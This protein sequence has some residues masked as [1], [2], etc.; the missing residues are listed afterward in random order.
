[1]T[2]VQTHLSFKNSTPPAI[3][4][5]AIV[6]VPHWQLK[7]EEIEVFCY[8]HC[9][10]L[11]MRGAFIAAFTSEK[12]W[13]TTQKIFFLNWP[14]IQ[15]FFIAHLPILVRCKTKSEVGAGC[16]LLRTWPLSA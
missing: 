3:D 1:V 11:Q 10:I 5:C 13:M 4:K 9:A 16:A 6:F 12:R 15:N 14:L 8:R 7:N 2:G